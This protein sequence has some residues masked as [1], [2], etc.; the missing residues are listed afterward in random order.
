MVNYFILVIAFSA[1]MSCIGRQKTPIVGLDCSDN[2]DEASAISDD[3]TENAGESVDT[4]IL[5]HCITGELKGSK[6]ETLFKN[7]DHY[8]RYIAHQQLKCGEIGRPAYSG[9][10]FKCTHENGCGLYSHPNHDELG[11]SPPLTS[12]EYL[13]DSEGLIL[14]KISFSSLP[15]NWY[16]VLWLDVPEQEELVGQ[17]GWVCASQ[18]K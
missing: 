8:S 13:V 16:C 2:C 11:V 17:V 10:V 6:C 15:K 5:E 14:R 18:C 1:L 3:S 7:P 12:K 9:A 4:E